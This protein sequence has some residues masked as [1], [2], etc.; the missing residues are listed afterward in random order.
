MSYN[1]NNLTK[2]AHLKLL[3][4]KIADKFATKADM[5]K[6]SGRVDKLETAGGEA[7]KLEG[8]KV[9]GAALAIADKMVDILIAT[10]TKNGTI[11]VNN[12]DVA[13]AGLMALAYKA[14]VSQADLDEALAA[15]LAAK[16]EQSDLSALSA[17]VTTLVGEDASKSVRAISAE[18]VAKIVAG[19]PESYDTLKEL[20][21]W[22]AAH[23]TDAAGMNSA[24]QAN[25]K[26]IASLKTLLGSIP[27]EA[28]S[29]NLVD[30]IAESIAAIG[31][32]NY[33]TTEAMN[34]ALSKRWTK[35]TARAC[36]PTTTPPPRKA[37]WRASPRAPPRW[38]LAPTRAASR[39]TA[40]RRRWCPLP[41]TRKPA[42]CWTRFLLRLD[43]YSGS[44]QRGTGCP[45]GSPT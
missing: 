18:E 6:L 32:G 27:E 41:P 29:S 12:A 23:E 26:D 20:A 21:D 40:P 24:I 22:L 5:T 30:Y 25:K 13:V 38:K 9:N 19:A 28:A 34:T 16:A 42:K 31:I 43:V 4:Q 45:A 8:V 17:K 3:A 2:L 14:K 33:A 39:S 11:K 35:R 15:V 1:E 44:V 36:P 10:G 7:N 37:S